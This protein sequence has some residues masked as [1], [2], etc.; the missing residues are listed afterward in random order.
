MRAA[1]LRTAGAP[2]L[3]AALVPQAGTATAQTVAE[4]ALAVFERG[5]L[6]KR[7]DFA[8]SAAAFGAL[9][10]ALGEAGPFR[11]SPDGAVLALSSAG[12]EL[13]EGT[14]PSCNVLAPGAAGASRAAMEAV[15]ESGVDAPL[16]HHAGPAITAGSFTADETH[17]WT[18]DETGHTA[19]AVLGIGA[20]AGLA[21]S[22]VMMP[23]GEESR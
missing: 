19:K 4:R 17:G 13:P 21:L 9:G 20:G 1:L 14:S 8:G 2:L 22:L 18:W 6:G 10:L 5:C 23:A 3:A 12:I 16:T 15:L 7:P 11:A